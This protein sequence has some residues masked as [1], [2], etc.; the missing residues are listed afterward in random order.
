MMEIDFEKFK[1]GSRWKTK[2]MW[3]VINNLGAHKGNAF[4]AWIKEVLEAKGVKTFG[5]ISIPGQED[6]RWRWK[7]KVIVSDITRKRLLVFPNDAKVY[8]I[9]PDGMSVASAIRASMAIPFFFRPVKIKRHGP[10][11]SYLVD[12]GM[13][14]NFPIWTFDS[15]REPACPTFGILLEESP[16]EEKD[17]MTETGRLKRAFRF[18]ND[19]I[20]T[21]MKAHDRRFVRPGDYTHRTISVPVGNVGTTEFDLSFE[22]KDKLYH[23]GRMATNKFLDEWKWKNYLQWCKKVRGYD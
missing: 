23:S 19:L 12:G 20:N 13:L 15:D 3:D 11:F 21:M 18:G 8:D 17:L 10:G 7:L 1:D 4:E 16:E 2:R 5:D 6:P 9:D 22:K 14:S